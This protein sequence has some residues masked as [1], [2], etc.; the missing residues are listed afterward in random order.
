[1]QDGITLDDISY[2]G[3]NL[4]AERT[5]PPPP[6]SRRVREE[7][8]DATLLSRRV[9]RIERKTTPKN[10]ARYFVFFLRFHRICLCRIYSRATFAVIVMYNLS[11]ISS[12]SLISCYKIDFARSI[13]LLDVDISQCHLVFVSFFSLPF[14]TCKH[15]RVYWIARFIEIIFLFSPFRI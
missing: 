4:R 12:Y 7:E 6:P 5:S 13:S 9:R 10:I 14:P 3:E 8:T 1:M 11:I 15:K 2:L